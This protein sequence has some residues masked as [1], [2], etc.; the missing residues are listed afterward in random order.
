VYSRIHIFGSTGYISSHRQQAAVMSSTAC[1]SKC[2]V[3]VLFKHLAKLFR[4]QSSEV[5]ALVVQFI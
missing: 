1:S 3:A 5:L 4:C 2:F